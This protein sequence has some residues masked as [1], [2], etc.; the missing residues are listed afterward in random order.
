MRKFLPKSAITLILTALVY[1]AISFFTSAFGFTPPVYGDP[2]YFRNPSMGIQ[3]MVPDKAQHY[4][5]SAMLTATSSKV[6][7]KDVGAVASL[8]AGFLWEIKDDHVGHGFSVRDLVADG[9]GVLTSRIGWSGPV[10]V[11]GDYSVTEETVSINASFS[12]K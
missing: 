11:Y 6:L 7:G 3:F 2:W 12:F 1:T 8:V 5:G 4:Y 9:L 10:K